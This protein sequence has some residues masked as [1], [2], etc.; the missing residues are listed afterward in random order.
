MSLHTGLVVEVMIDTH[1]HG[2]DTHVTYCTSTCQHGFLLSNHYYPP[3]TCPSPHSGMKASTTTA[4]EDDLHQRTHR[5]ESQ[6]Q[7]DRA[8]L[9]Q[10]SSSCARPHSRY[11]VSLLIIS[12]T[13]SSHSQSSAHSHSSA[14]SYRH[15]THTRHLTHIVTPHTRSSS[16]PLCPFTAFLASKCPQTRQRQVSLYTVRDVTSVS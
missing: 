16:R 14:H 1:V 12:L 8:R 6:T 2:V 3:P 9:F 13:S 4:A 5:W 10:A 15:L 11:C 7:A